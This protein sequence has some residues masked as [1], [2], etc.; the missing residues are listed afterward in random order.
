VDPVGLAIDRRV[1]TITLQTPENRNALSVRL[2]TGLQ[3][4]LDAAMEDPEVRVIV[5]T[6]AGPVFCAGA[7]LKENSQAGPPLPRILRR[8]LDG[9]KPVIAVLN[10]PAR[11]GG[12][13]LVA[14]C[15]LAIAPDTATFAFTEV[16]LGLIPAI[17]SVPCLQRMSSR[18]AARY[19]L[20]GEVFDAAAAVES[21]LLTATGASDD[22]GVMADTIAS[23][24]AL[25]A[26]TAL[27][28]TKRLLREV[29]AMATDVAFDYTQ[30][31]SE[32]FFMSEDATEGRASFAEKRPPRWAT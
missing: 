15:D 28:A 11:A 19:F 29:P 1:A 25:G 17:I 16:R 27:A 6:G 22:V 30:R 14:A 3:E 32:M 4:A 23:A 18:A 26:P 5:L 31:I 8:I 13:G 9:P 2:R 7:D 20:T 10:G 21:G 12:I 24:I